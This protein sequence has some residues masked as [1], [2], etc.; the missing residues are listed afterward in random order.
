MGDDDDFIEIDIL[1][2]K[3]SSKILPI[4][5]FYENILLRTKLLTPKPK[6]PHRTFMLKLHPGNY[7]VNNNIMT[8]GSINGNDTLRQRINQPSKDRSRCPHR[9]KGAVPEWR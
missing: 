9:Q 7:C 2:C 4:Y 6:G 8:N 3:E 5:L 1:L